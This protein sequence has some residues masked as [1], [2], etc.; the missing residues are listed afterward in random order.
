MTQR[1]EVAGLCLVYLAVKSIV[2]CGK[3]PLTAFH[4]SC[5][6]LHVKE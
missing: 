1:T 4:S 2:C 3:S 6:Y 5:H